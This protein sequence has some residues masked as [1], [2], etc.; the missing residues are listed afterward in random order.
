V[1]DETQE[2]KGLLGRPAGR[3]GEIPRE[4][5]TQEGRRLLL[6]KKVEVLDT[7]EEKNPEVG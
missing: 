5:E 3:K 1:A 2:R 6:N 7:G 4:V